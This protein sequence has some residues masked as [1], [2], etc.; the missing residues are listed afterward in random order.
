MKFINT[1]FKVEGSHTSLIFT[2]L[3]ILFFMNLGIQSIAQSRT[4]WQMHFADG[5]KVTGDT[6]EH[7]GDSTEY[8]LENIP[9]VNDPLWQAAPRGDL[10]EYA[11]ASPFCH[12]GPDSTWSCRKW[13]DYTYFQTFITIPSNVTLTTFT[14][15]LRGIDDG[16]KVRMYNSI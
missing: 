14:I 12:I 10:I 15:R 11:M 2:L 6:A 7:Y 9:P 8:F 5:P 1:P 3:I 13:V 4:P 16:V